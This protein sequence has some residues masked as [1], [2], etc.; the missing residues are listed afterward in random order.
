M[1]QH[2][3][4]ANQ[5]PVLFDPKALALMRRTV[6]A[7]TN[8]DEFDLF[9][10]MA[11]SLSLDPLRRQ[12]YAL[13]Y[14]KDKPDKRRMSIIVGIDG[15]RSVAARSGNY[16]PDE[17]EPVFEYD[18]ERKGPHNPVG[19][20][21]CVSKIF[22]FAHGQ[23]H[24]VSGVAY[25]DE[26]VPM[27]ERWEFD[28]EQNKRVPT[29]V[30]ELDPTSQ[31]ARMPRV[32]LAKC[33]EAIAIRKA[34]PEDLSNVYEQ[35]EV[36]RFA[37]ELTA[38]EAAERGAQ[39]ERQLRIGSKGSIPL[40][41]DINAGLEMVPAGQV[42]DRVMAHVEKLTQAEVQLWRSRN[43]AGLREYWAVSQNDALALKGELDLRSEN[44]DLIH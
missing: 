43:L 30:F 39:E 15:F 12:I 3:S 32:M 14:N 16:R 6:A 36:D 37:I 35:S 41:F 42:Y 21:R 11:R 13:V 9:V 38:S 10:A 34:F 26:F 17:D 40:V 7:D 2:V 18:P 23:W 24:K 4:I 29:G 20:V 5:A 44:D 33:A 28:R 27:K 31:W 19:L 25:W 1:A 8:Q 22:V